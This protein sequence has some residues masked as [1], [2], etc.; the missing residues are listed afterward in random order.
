MVGEDW[1]AMLTTRL[2]LKSHTQK[3][4]FFSCTVLLLS[5]CNVK[6]KQNR[7]W[8]ASFGQVT[9]FQ[10]SLPHTPPHGTEA[11]RNRDCSWRGGHNGNNPSFQP[12]AAYI[13]QIALINRWRPLRETWARH[14]LWSW[15]NCSLKITDWTFKISP[16]ER[17]LHMHILYLL[18]LPV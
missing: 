12:P 18:P 2:R 6:V 11:W 1:N 7:N 8:K 4:I 3:D 15:L 10:L 13:R 9:L 14:L 16:H 5:Y 17:M